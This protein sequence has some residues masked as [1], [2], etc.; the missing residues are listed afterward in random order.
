MLNFRAEQPVF[1]AVY[2]EKHYDYCGKFAE[3]RFKWDCLVEYAQVF[4]PVCYSFLPR[5]A[6]VASR[7]EA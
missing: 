2:V 7:N 5:K 6:R 3:N 1:C 4:K